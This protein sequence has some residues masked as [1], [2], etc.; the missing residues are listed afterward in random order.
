MPTPLLPLPRG[1]MRY[2]TAGLLLALAA[3]PAAEAQ[4]TSMVDPTLPSPTELRRL[5]EAIPEV[6]T[7]EPAPARVQAVEIKRTRAESK[8]AESISA[9]TVLAIIGGVVVV[10][11]LIALF[12]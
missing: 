4:Q 9:R 3:V 7:S 8:S 11:A 12:S 2:V 5:P 6:R 10:V 1:F